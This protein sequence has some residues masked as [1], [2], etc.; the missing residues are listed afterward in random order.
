MAN[1][2]RLKILTPHGIKFDQDIKM[3]EVK[4]P[5]GYIGIMYNHVPFVANL[6]AN[7]VYITHLDDRREPAVLDTAT[8]Y[9]KREEIKIFGLNFVLAKDI[10]IE[11]A[12]QKKK[13]LEAQLARINDHR[14]TAKIERLLAFQLL[15]LK[16]SRSH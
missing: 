1:P 16:E 12:N 4:A 10:D 2:I 11:K 9:S 8:I 7:V 5:E 13:Q 3:I 6:V 15:Q 14:E